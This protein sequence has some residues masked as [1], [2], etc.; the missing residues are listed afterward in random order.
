[1]TPVIG[2]QARALRIEG[3]YRI[4]VVSHAAVLSDY[5]KAFETLV[6]LHPNVNVTLVTPKA[7]REGAAW[8]E[9]Q[10]SAKKLRVMPLLVLLAPRQYVHFYCG[11]GRLLKATQPDLVHLDEEP[12]SLVAAQVSWLARRFCPEAKL[13]FYTWENLS[14]KWRGAR[15][16]YRL[17]ERTVY[18][19]ADG[20]LA[21]TH[22]AA[23]VLRQRG[24][25]KPVWVVP[26]GIDTDRFYAPP[27]QC[28]GGQE[29]RVGYAGRLLPEKGVDTLIEAV[30]QLSPQAKL[31]LIGDGSEREKLLQQVEQTK[32]QG[33]VTFE[34]PIAHRDMPAWLVGLDVLVL[35]SRRTPWWE[36]QF[37]RVLVE[38]MACGVP[39]V[40]SDTGAIPEVLGEAGLVFKA[41]APQ[42]LVEC[43]RQLM[44]DPALRVELGG[45]GRERALQEY[46]SQH[47]A[48][49]LYAIYGQVLGAEGPEEKS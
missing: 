47:V 43:L 41:D 49:R 12:A 28:A 5:R 36:E 32:L 30:R 27:R 15:R 9:C 39:V 38:A 10:P 48:E 16:L 45:K 34:G 40:G 14:Q 19:A 1:M 25:S 29:F 22:G 33:A 37:G 8:V 21:A 20:A 6:E 18:G 42:S 23:E 44:G 2:P 17:C 46:S 35:P 4:L 13:L 24:F 26:P 31:T 3:P 7:W 11:L